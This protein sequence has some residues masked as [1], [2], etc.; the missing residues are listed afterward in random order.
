VLSKLRKA[1]GVLLGHSTMS[2]AAVHRPL[3]SFAIEYS[4]RIGQGSNFFNLTPLT[5]G[6]SSGSVIAVR[7]NQAAIALGTQTYGSLAHLVSRYGIAT[8]SY[9]HDTPRALASSMKNVAV[10]LDIIHGVDAC[11]TLTVQA[12]A[13]SPIKGCAA[14]IVG[15]NALK[16][17]KLDVP[18][19]AYW[20]FKGYVSS[21]R[22]RNVYMARIEDLQA[23]GAKIYNI[24]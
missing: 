12:V 14:E 17:M 23:A 20:K 21:P 19:D 9:G 22:V 10:L 8:G 11:D 2:E 13:H 1:G 4:I 6:T 16:S 15:E 5:A 24:L 7:S 3:K 18:W